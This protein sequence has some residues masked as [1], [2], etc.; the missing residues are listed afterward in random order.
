MEEKSCVVTTQPLLLSFAWEYVVLNGQGNE[1][2]LKMIEKCQLL[3][4]VDDG[5]ILGG[6][7]RVVREK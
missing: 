7:F 4:H 3:L 1:E 5:E 2:A 6:N